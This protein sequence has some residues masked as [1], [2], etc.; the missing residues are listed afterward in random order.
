MGSFPLPYRALHA[1]P[2]RAGDW[3]SAGASPQR[4]TPGVRLC[5]K[6]GYIAIR[7]M[8]ATLKEQQSAC[9]WNLRLA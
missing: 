2:W 4:L 6:G 5:W 8:T 7:H 1:E 3:G 9:W